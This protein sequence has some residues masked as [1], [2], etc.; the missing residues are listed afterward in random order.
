MLVAIQTLRFDGDSLCISVRYVFVD[1]VP[2]FQNVFLYYIDN[3]L[4]SA[5]PDVSLQSG[6]SSTR[7]CLSPSI[8]HRSYHNELNDNAGSDFKHICVRLAFAMVSD[9]NGK[10]VLTFCFTTSGAV[11][12]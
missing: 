6:M 4:L 7:P 9:P 1:L 8:R 10:V 2:G 3:C 5:L 12:L 11:K